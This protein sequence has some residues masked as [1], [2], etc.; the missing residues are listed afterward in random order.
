MAFRS[1][2]MAILLISAVVVVTL[3]SASSDLTGTFGAIAATW[4][5]IHQVPVFIDDVQLGVLPLLPTALMMWVVARRCA[6]AAT[7][8]DT[9]V[10]AARL[11]G[12]AVA[13][14]LTVTAICLAVVADASAAIPLSS[15]NALS[16]FGWVAGIHLVAAA[17]GVAVAHW[18]IIEPELPRWASA[19]IRP[20]AWTT[21]ALLAAGSVAVLC[22]L[23]ISWSTVGDL[24]SRGGGFVGVLGLTVL[25]LLY[26]PNLVVGAVAVMTGASADIGDV[27]TSVFGNVGGDL[28]PLPILGA[29]P[30]GQGGGFWPVLLVVPVAIGIYLG[31]DCARRVGGQDGILTAVAAAFM[32]GTVI[33][34][35]AL[36]SGGE[37]GYFGAVEVTWW[38]VG[39]LTFGWLALFGSI[40][41]LITTWLQHRAVPA[42]EPTVT[43]PPVEVAGSAE[44]AEPAE[45]EDDEASTDRADESVDETDSAHETETEEPD[46]PELEAEESTAEEST[47]EV[48]KAEEVEVDAVTVV[49]DSADESATDLPS[50]VK[51]PSD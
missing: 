2:G 12:A 5:A 21:T 31:R 24:L 28:P 23:L 32:S 37:L 9:R 39:L 40:S 22:A 51:D 46:A 36:A 34:F 41:A 11:V 42:P 29:V 30:A 27:S 45:A 47:A 18:Q 6:S 19:A 44:V 4:L 8:V 7:L 10:A 48:S 35:L 1:S 17:V 26:L 14:P 16:A 3:V 15:P 49:D 38:A 25:S 50:P 43:A 20:G 13:G 33:A